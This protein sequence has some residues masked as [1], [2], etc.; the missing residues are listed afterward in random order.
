MPRP[1]QAMTAGP[2][3]VTAGSYAITA[4]LHPVNPA[5]LIMYF[6]ASVGVYWTPVAEHGVEDAQ[7][8]AHAGGA[9]HDPGAI[10]ARGAVGVAQSR[11]PFH[12]M[13]VL[14]NDVAKALDDPEKRLAPQRD[15]RS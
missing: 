1:A 12:V 15:Q 7:Q 14:T 13:K 9:G 6:T 10:G 11:Q 8:L 2:H 3:E 5:T 4:G